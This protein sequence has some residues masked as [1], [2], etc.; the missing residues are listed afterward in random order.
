MNE[1]GFVCNAMTGKMRY[2]MLLEIA[3]VVWPLTGF[4]ES[5]ALI[6]SS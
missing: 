5:E 2:I 1:G 3:F 6:F 4:G